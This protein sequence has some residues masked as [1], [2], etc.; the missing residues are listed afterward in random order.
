[1]IKMRFVG[2][3]VGALAVL[4]VGLAMPA[5]AA[6]RTF[7]GTLAF[8]AP[9]DVA[10]EVMPE[11]TCP[12][13][14]ELDGTFYKFIDLEGGYKNFKLEGPPRLFTDP[15]G[16]TKTG[17]YDLDIYVY[18][19][20]CNQIGEG[21]TSGAT[22]KFDLKKKARYAVVHYYVGIHPDLPFT[23]QVANGRIK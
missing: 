21:V 5:Q 11:L 7:E 3:S 16:V 1:M 19:D 13:S 14:G 9:V 17:D 4:A 8:S 23:L 6:P 2:L 18:D 12:E 22:E 10:S 20:K 15:S